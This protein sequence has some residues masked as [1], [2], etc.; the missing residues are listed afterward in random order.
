[1]ARRMRVPHTD[2]AERAAWYLRGE[3]HQPCAVG[4]ACQECAAE[5][6]QWRVLWQQRPAHAAADPVE[7]GARQLIECRYASAAADE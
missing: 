7:A 5:L 6:A 3:G 1:M 2:P 4:S